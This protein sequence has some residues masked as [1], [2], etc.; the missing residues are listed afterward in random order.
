MGMAWDG[1]PAVLLLDTMA[2]RPALG[3]PVVIDRA[4][5]VTAVVITET[6]GANPVSVAL[7]TG[8]DGTGQLLLEATVPA[9]STWAW[10]TG[11]PGLPA[12]AGVWAVITAGQGSVS[13]TTAERITR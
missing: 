4:R 6:S 5:W 1:A 3:V 13:V 2:A 10:S 11:L 9:G 12:P 7:W 8:P